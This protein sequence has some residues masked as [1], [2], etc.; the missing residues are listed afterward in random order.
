LG[1]KNEEQRNLTN[2]R[3]NQLYTPAQRP[4]QRSVQ[5]SVQKPVQKPV[6]I[7]VERHQVDTFNNIQDGRR[8]IQKRPIFIYQSLNVEQI[9]NF[10]AVPGS[11]TFTFYFLVKLQ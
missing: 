8:L 7:P 10:E 11:L 5:R 3:Y 2:Q 9:L 4:V 6:Q 1:K